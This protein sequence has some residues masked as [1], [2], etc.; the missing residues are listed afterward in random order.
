MVDGVAPS[1]VISCSA[2]VV[3][4]VLCRFSMSLLSF[5]ILLFVVIQIV[6]LCGHFPSVDEGEFSLAPGREVVG[7]GDSRIMLCDV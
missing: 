4:I 2:V 5:F 1:V 3:A 6:F 7:R